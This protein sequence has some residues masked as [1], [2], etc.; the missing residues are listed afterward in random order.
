MSNKGGCA[1]SKTMEESKES[2]VRVM[3]P[4]DAAVRA[5]LDAT[6]VARL[7][8]GHSRNTAGGSPT[9]I[10]VGAAKI[11]AAAT[12]NAVRIAE[13][14]AAVVAARATRSTA[15]V[16]GR[17]RKRQKSARQKSS[18]LR[19]LD[20]F[21]SPP[22]GD[23]AERVF[24]PSGLLVAENLG[25]SADSCERCGRNTHDTLDCAER[26]DTRGKRV[27]ELDM[28]GSDGEL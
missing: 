28:P 4:T 24:S 5:V 19:L 8:A 11:A 17:K 15:V 22:L 2:K 13:L 6:N 25:W 3:S 14:A 20:D 27:E 7:A 10:R 18:M 12:E 21:T 16:A 9:K 23:R 26:Y 1:L